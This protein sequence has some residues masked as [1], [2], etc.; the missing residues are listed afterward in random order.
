MKVGKCL[1]MFFK[2][3]VFQMFGGFET[4]EGREGQ[5]TGAHDV[6]AITVRVQSRN[7]SGEKL[8]KT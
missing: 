7:G 2:I 3:S 1:K 6:C 8:I 4:F 5:N